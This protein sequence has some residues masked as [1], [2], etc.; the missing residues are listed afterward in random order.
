MTKFFLR[1]FFFP[2]NIEIAITCG[3]F[4]SGEAEWGRKLVYSYQVKPK[5]QKFQEQGTTL[6]EIT[7]KKGYRGK[8]K[9][10]AGQN[11][12]DKHAACFFVNMMGIQVGISI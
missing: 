5:I 3:S 6:R 2:K 9:V 12:E 10:E 4:V 1:I 7:R 8:V 11:A